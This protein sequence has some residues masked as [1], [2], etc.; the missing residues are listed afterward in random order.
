MKLPNSL[1]RAVGSNAHGSRMSGTSE[2]PLKPEAVVVLTGMLS[3]TL[4][5]CQSFLGSFWSF[6]TTWVMV[7]VNVFP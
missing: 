4:S 1:K 2:A 6:Q 3:W 5:R 7:C